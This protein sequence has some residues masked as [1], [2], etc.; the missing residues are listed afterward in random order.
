MKEEDGDKSGRDGANSSVVVDTTTSPRD[1]AV[2]PLPGSEVPK[3]TVTSQEDSSARSHA[4]DRTFDVENGNET[5]RP[6]TRIEKRGDSACC[7]FNP[8]GSFPVSF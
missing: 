3:I 2:S 8:I 7:I 4:S 5:P 6:V 1:G